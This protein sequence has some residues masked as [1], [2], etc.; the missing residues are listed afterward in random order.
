MGKSDLRET[1][2]QI[3]KDNGFEPVKA[4]RG[5][6]HLK[7][8]KDGLTVTLPHQLH[9]RGMAM[10]I[11][12]QQAGLVVRLAF[13]GAVVFLAHASRARDS[14]HPPGMA[15][16]AT[17]R[18]Y[19][20]LQDIKGNEC[21][22]IADCRPVIAHFKDSRW[23]VLVTKET[24]GPLAP[25]SWLPVPAEKLINRDD[26]PIGKSVACMNRLDNSFYCFTPFIGG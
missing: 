20:S 15:P 7:F 3:L 2:I 9:D 19:Q 23:E 4:N 17:G 25:D 5:T 11:L 24:W 26:N 21:C 1:A 22:A 8:K 10:R 16:T 6:G 12:K 14:E 13:V 18:W